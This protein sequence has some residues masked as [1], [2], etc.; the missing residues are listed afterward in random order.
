[1][2]ETG[3]LA[4]NLT[5]HDHGSS[6]EFHLIRANEF[7]SLATCAIQGRTRVQS[8][9]ISAYNETHLFQSNPRYVSET[10]ACNHGNSASL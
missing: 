7:F 8:R 2:I 9:R 1:M 6:C 4:T 5:N 10:G 3:Q